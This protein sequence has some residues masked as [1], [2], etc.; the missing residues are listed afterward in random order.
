M[1]KEVKNAVEIIKKEFP[2]VLADSVREQTECLRT[3]A[4]NN[5]RIENIIFEVGLSEIIK[6]INRKGRIILGKLPVN[7]SDMNE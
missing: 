6:K 1:S 4:D 2:D 3:I 7:E 5:E